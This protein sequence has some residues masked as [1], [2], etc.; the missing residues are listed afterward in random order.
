MP[1]LPEV[2]TIRR[3]LLPLVVGRRVT[4]VCVEPAT[5]ALLL[6]TSAGR[7]QEAVRGRVVRDLGRRGKY[8]LFRLDD[9]RTWAA[10]LRMTGRVVWRS[11]AAPP[12]PYERARVRFDDD[13]ELRWCDLRKF[14]RWV[15]VDDEATLA[16]A[17]GPEPLEPAF[18]FPYLEQLLRGRRAP[19]KA[20]L[21]DQRGIA[22]LGNIYADEA[23]FAAGIRPTRPAGELTHAEV[24]RL[25][26]AIRSVIAEG[27]ANRGASFRDYVDGH[28]GDGYQQMYVRVFRRTGKPCYQCGTPVA[29]TVV[30]G[31]STHFCPGCQPPGREAGSP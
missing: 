27:I 11:K 1:E 14:G 3:D 13:H 15:I 21:L 12:E 25:H 8:L 16:A 9:G 17:L 30:A 2:E 24:A 20:I 4:S 28:G 31:R 19:V 18:T 7:F 22:G 10:H 6:G 23:L 5:E 29:R 26:A